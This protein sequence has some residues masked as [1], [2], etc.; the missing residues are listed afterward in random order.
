MVTKRYFPSLLVTITRHRNRHEWDEDVR[1]LIRAAG[2]IT[3]TAGAI[4]LLFIGYLVWGTALKAASA[5]RQLTHELNQQL[6][7]SPSRDIV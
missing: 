3:L 6:A 1:Q 7:T 5:Q 2:E 4:C